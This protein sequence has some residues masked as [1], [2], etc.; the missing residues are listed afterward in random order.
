MQHSPIP[1]KR[2][3]VFASLVFEL[4]ACAQSPS[5]KGAVQVSATVQASPPRITLGW[6]P[7]T[8][9]SSYTVYRRVQ[10]ATGWGT[11]VANLSGSALQYVDN[12]V[13][14]GVVYEYKVTRSALGAGYG[15]VLSAVA[16]PPVEQRGTMVLLV[17]SAMATDVAP[18]I[19]QL[20]EDLLGDGWW[21]E[22]EVVPPTASPVAVR[23][24]VQSIHAASPGQVKAVYVLGHVAVPYSGNT[25]PDGHAEHRGAWPCDGYYGDL[26]GVWTDVT[27]N[28]TGAVNLWNHNVPGDGKFDQT[29]FPSALELPVGRVDLNELPAFGQ[30]AAQL[31][32]AYL[33]KAHQWKTKALVVPSTSVVFD[34]L[35]WVNNPLASSGYMSLNTSSGA[36]SLTDLPPSSG[37]FVNTFTSVDNLWTYHSGT[38]LQGVGS[39]GQVTF[40]G[41]NNGVTT[42]G[43]AAAPAAGIFNMSFGSYFGDWDNEDNYLRAV[44][45]SGKALTHVWSGIPNWFFHPM[46][47]GEPIGYCARRSMNNTNQDLSLQ[48]GGWQGQS[49]SR[50]HM[51]LMG[52]PSL[53]QSYLAPPTDLV[54]TSSTWYADFTWSPSPEPVDGYHI[55]R[56]DTV[57]G[58]LVRI[59]ITPVVGT[60]FTSSVPF[61]PGDRYMVRAIK[62][63]VSNT[64]SYHDLSLGALA[65]AQGAP[66]VDCQGI[67]GGAALPGTFCDDGDADTLDDV[68]DTDC[69]CGGLSVGVGELSA[70]AVRWWTDMGASELHVQLAEPMRGT[71]RL[72]DVQG[73]TLRE[74]VVNGE[75]LQVDVQALAP[76]TYLIELRPS[77]A[78]GSP[79]V[80]RF[81]LV[82]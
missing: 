72:R 59:T 50:G 12:G 2:T 31:L 4:M 25:N 33:Y 51:A 47:L 35:Q 7:F 43:L 39:N 78:G 46:A 21:V 53:R 73:A 30:S 29:D 32:Q 18:S 22:R 9:S 54:V 11:A 44:L 14:V 26:D 45:A 69:Q 64:G 5:R 67:S 17:D 49:M 71:F 16:R 42:A 63:V 52:D 24:L 38:G 48:N 76:A 41:T 3:L 6:E 19:A 65:Y 80:R 56:I 1:L 70:N 37:P 75:R 55:Y 40:I 15:Y 61:V 13:L 20:E 82:R 10:G 60:S 23:A 68:Y 27:V 28:A 62:L 8:G 34:D 36:S 74:G 58:Q 79:L 81:A 57:A 66:L 77:Q